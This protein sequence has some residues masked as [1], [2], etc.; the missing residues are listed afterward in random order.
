MAK[1]TKKRKV[2]TG[3]KT[4][5]RKVVTGKKAKRRKVVTGKNA[6]RRNG[7]APKKSQKRKLQNGN[8]WLHLPIELPKR[9]LDGKL[10]LAYYAVKNNYSVIIGRQPAVYANAKHFPRGIFFSKGY[11]NASG[12]RH[13]PL[14]NIKKMG[15]AIVE[16]DEEGLLLD[17][18]IKFISDR[19]TENNYKILNQIYCWGNEQENALSKA[20]P[21]FKNRL[22]VTGHP[23][24]DLLRKKFRSVHN[25]EVEKIK[26]KYGDFILINTR[27]SIYNHVSGDRFQ[28]LPTAKALHN[29][30]PNLYSHLRDLYHHFIKMIK[31]LSYSYPNLNIVIRP[32]PSESKVSYQKEFQN[33][34]NVFIEHEGT[35]AKWNL[36]SNIVIH[37]S[38]TTG[39]EAFL[40]GKPVISYRPI[41]SNQHDEY[42]PNAVSYQ[43]TNVKEVTSFIDKYLSTGKNNNLIP[44]QPF[45]RKG[46]KLLSNYC[47]AIDGNYAYENI[48][49]KLDKIKIK[50][51][52]S[53]QR[54]KISKKRVKTIFVTRSKI[55]SF[56][57]KLDKIEGVKNKRT[58]SQLRQN[59]FLIEPKN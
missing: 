20:Y 31:S 55:Q 33:Y 14:R 49:R 52:A 19:T 41:T 4:K 27:F 38:C 48:I 58:V 50:G 21:K 25:D 57:N 44:D 9:E 1:K 40:L 51:K 56:F 34:N 22:F 39:L 54:K 59:L 24:F 13:G 35:I 18:D 53:L 2:V 30:Y 29:R 16:L 6:K 47:G 3:K 7:V 23:R 28:R 37:N 26:K 5:R 15:H 8:K 46:K 36:A 10:L 17:R 45:N 11:P 12:Y 42:L 32:H 43:A